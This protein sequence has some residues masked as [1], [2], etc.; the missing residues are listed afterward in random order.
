MNKLKGYLDIH[1]LLIYIFLSLTLFG[2]IYVGS[3]EI[4]FNNHN[5][6]NYNF[7]ALLKNI[8][9]EYALYSLTLTIIM[10]VLSLINSTIKK[11]VEI[12]MIVSLIFGLLNLVFFPVNTLLDGRETVDLL[13][14]EGITNILLL[15]AVIV[16][17]IIIYIKS[18]EKNKLLVFA[19]F[20]CC[21]YITFNTVSA[22]TA[23]SY[24][25]Q[26]N[27]MQISTLP[28][29]VLRLSKEKN[30]IYIVLDQFDT[31]YFN[32][33]LE[34]EDADFY[35]D[36][37]NDFTFFS[38]YASAHPTTV[39]SGVASMAGRP[40]DNSL[41]YAKE[42]KKNVFSEG[43]SLFEKLK[44]EG[45]DNI[46]YV[47]GHNDPLYYAPQIEYYSNKIKG[48]YNN[49]K[50][51]ISK[52]YVH[53]AIYR[54]SPLF[55]RNKAKLLLATSDKEGWDFKFIKMLKTN[56][57]AINNKNV[58]MLL[59]LYAAHD[60]HVINENIEYDKSANAVSQAKASLKVTKM[61]LDKIKNT[62]E[63]LYNNSLIIVTT[64][65]GYWRPNAICFIKPI[66][67]HNKT[68]LVD[69]RAVSQIYI[70]D[71]IYDLLHGKQL[72]DIDTSKP[73]YF[74]DYE[75]IKELPNGYF[76]SIYKYQLP[77]KLLEEKKYDLLKIYRKTSGVITSKNLKV[78]F[79]GNT[80]L[81]YGVDLSDG[82]QITS[83]GLQ[84]DK[85]YK[86]ITFTFEEHVKKKI[87]LEMEYECAG[88]DNYL[89]IRTFDVTGKGRMNYE[90]IRLNEKKVV[91]NIDAESDVVLQFD[92]GDKITIKNITMQIENQ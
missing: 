63:D 2:F 20:I 52:K 17:S 80:N 8:I 29:D 72:A 71:I 60:P 24:Q 21:I 54:T 41:P 55:L 58:F 5:E 39:F 56:N 11:N 4:F 28:E 36:I 65:H 92:V 67:A 50:N 87:N 73:R 86:V 59:H 79:M 69:D 38:N 3:V 19:G 1:R 61:F 46:I 13:S 77:D 14:K 88:P 7:I 66:N 85:K 18:N 78:N 90:P 42:Y 30:I 10:Y 82:W 26:D 91:Y 45:Y 15:I 23:S 9:I 62:S 25:S 6:Y 81:P 49:D 12:I 35:K 64:D 27:K 84:T 57:I 83:S 40:Y 51:K 16:L 31:S 48:D 43:N 76:S 33:I 32:K 53:A 74:Y 37:F 75:Y 89:Y 22:I 70:K 34:S 44:K 47:T 68:M